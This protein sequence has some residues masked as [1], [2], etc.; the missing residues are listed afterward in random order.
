TSAITDSQAWMVMGRS[1]GSD[2]MVL[3]KDVVAANRIMDTVYGRSAIFSALLAVGG[4]SQTPIINERS[5]PERLVAR[6]VQSHL[7]ACL[8]PACC[9]LLGLAPPSPVVAG[10]IPNKPEVFAA[11]DELRSHP[12]AASISVRTLMQ[13]R[14]K[15][16]KPRQPRQEGTRREKVAHAVRHYVP[17]CQDTRVSEKPS[18]Y[19]LP[20][21]EPPKEICFDPVNLHSDWVV[22]P[23]N[24]L[25]HSAHQEP[26]AVFDPLGPRHAQ[27]HS[28]NDESLFWYSL[29]RRVAPKPDQRR[30]LD[31]S[32]R[33]RL[34]QLKQGYAKFMPTEQLQF[35]D[36]LMDDCV[37]DALAPWF[38]GKTVS[39]IQQAV[40][41]WD[42]SDDPMLYRVFQKGQWIKKLEAK[43]TPPK[44]SQIITQVHLDRI[45]TDAIYALY[46]ERVKS[47]I[48]PTSTL[49]FAEKNPT[50]LAEW[51]SEHWEPDIGVTN[52]DY[53]GWDTGMDL[54]FLEFSCW[55]QRLYG[56]PDHYVDTYRWHRRHSRTFLGAFPIMQA[57]GDRK[58]FDDNSDR[59]L[60]ITGA[61]LDCP[62]GTP[63]IV[64][65]D[66]VAVPGRFKRART[67]RPS[68]WPLT[69]KL[70]EAKRV[71]CVGY[72]FGGP[73]LY[74]SSK[75]FIHHVEIG[76]Q[77]GTT[78]PSYW[79]S[80]ADRLPL[81]RASPEEWG[82]IREK[83]RIAHDCLSAAAPIF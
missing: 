22:N 1:T 4:R 37:V 47:A 40:S 18:T 6:A 72:T 41:R 17:I 48:R 74:A 61:S 16:T 7:A 75:S 50:Q 30:T 57:S 79:R 13:T 58:T 45:F 29:K 62:K 65:G 49:L 8:S 20:T 32:G 28:T 71:E 70:V 42:F 63:I 55:L 15:R 80:F 52:T 2:W 54:P 78:D 14:S 26:T 43:D 27:H 39:A 11:M 60:A 44:K 36:A 83:L 35:N 56:V 24:E 77:R 34:R 51:Y 9:A 19:S 59:D 69:V 66:D 64:C 67:F 82:T 5:D 76:T 73:E 10:E 33:I 12:D 46:F 23:D 3:P 25:S 21:F 53:T 81:I 38:A 68:A 31:E